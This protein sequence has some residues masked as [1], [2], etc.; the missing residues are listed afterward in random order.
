MCKQFVTVQD[1]FED[2]ECWN[3]STPVHSAALQFTHV[4][5]PSDDVKTQRLPLL[6]V[7]SQVSA[8]GDKSPRCSLSVSSS[9]QKLKTFAF[10]RS[11]RRVAT[12]SDNLPPSKKPASDKE[13]A[14]FSNTQHTSSIHH[15][16]PSTPSSTV[17]SVDSNSLFVGSQ[18]MK[19][20]TPITSVNNKYGSET[21][22]LPVTPLSRH[23]MAKRKFPGPAGLLPKLV[24]RLFCCV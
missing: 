17:Q 4:S 24:R 6:Q 9:S 14:T 10:S 23:P 22:S 2:D 7:H 19:S 1:F 3:T 5:D 8:G 16:M 12:D 13:I 20:S 21:P 11:S 18:V 15:P